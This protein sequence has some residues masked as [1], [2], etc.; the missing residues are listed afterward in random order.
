MED[1]EETEQELDEELN[2]EIDACLAELV[3]S[4]KVFVYT[5]ENGVEMFYDKHLL[6]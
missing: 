1:V 4:G 3:A 5:D 6:N 2:A